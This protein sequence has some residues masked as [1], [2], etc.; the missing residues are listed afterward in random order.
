M[1]LCYKLVMSVY[2]SDFHKSWVGHVCVFLHAAM[3]GCSNFI[4]HI[5][6][7]ALLVRAVVAPGGGADDDGAS[8][9][10]TSAGAGSAD[11][12]SLT[13][14]FTGIGVLIKSCKLCGCKSGD[15]S[16]LETAHD[17]DEWG[18]K[19]P[20]DHYTRVSDVLKKCSG[21]VCRFCRSTFELGSFA[22][23]HGNIAAYM[24]W[25]KAADTATRHHVFMRARGAYV[26]NLMACGGKRSSVHARSELE[27]AKRVESE[28]KEGLRNVQPLKF[29]EAG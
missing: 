21:R 11:L 28:D 24:E 12:S 26:A 16:P 10:G 23:E 7:A 17:D 14:V 6:V 8:V 18:G 3:V 22:V 1:I 5:A 20:W 15:A 29:T 27:K 2:H 25:R 19:I 9:G 13:V 4:L